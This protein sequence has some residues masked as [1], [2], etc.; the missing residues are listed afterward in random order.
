MS[1]IDLSYK[2][3]LDELREIH[4]RLRGDDVDIDRL[5]EDVGRAS[6]LLAFCRERLTSVGERLEEVL[7]DFE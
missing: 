7:T 2:E 6:E 4:A 3:A 1:D 5:L